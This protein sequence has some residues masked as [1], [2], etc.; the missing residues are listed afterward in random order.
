[1]ATPLI[2]C[3]SY[4]IGFFDDKEIVEYCAETV[5]CHMEQVEESSYY[6]IEDE[7]VYIQTQEELCVDN[8]KDNLNYTASLGCK[9]EFRE[10]MDC[11]MQHYPM[12][13]DY[14]MS[15]MEDIEEYYEDLDKFWE[16]TCWSEAEK[17]EACEVYY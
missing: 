10:Y 1:L 14:D 11:V 12:S 13:C 8:Y 4:S 15:D 2:G 5:E 16:K 6:D 17:I 3:D 9:A 7:D